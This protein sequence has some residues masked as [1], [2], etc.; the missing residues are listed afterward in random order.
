MQSEF[1][2]TAIQASKNAEK[3]IMQYYSED[4]KVEIKKDMTPVTIADK[5]AEKIIIKTIMSKFPDHEILGEE[6]GRTGESEYQWVI[7]P[8]DGTKNYMKKIPIFGTLIALVKNGE[9]IVGVSNLPALQ[10]MIY[11]EKGKG[12]WKVQGT[13]KRLHVSNCSRVSDS[14]LNSGNITRFDKLGFKNN[15]MNLISDC[16]RQRGFGD[17]YMY[18]TVCEG[19]FDAAIES[20]LSFWDIAPFAIIIPEAGGKI[21]DLK[22]RSIDIR[23]DTCVASNG[24]IHDEILKYFKSEQSIANIFK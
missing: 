15:V 23:A 8:I 16:S 24:R 13:K 11:A 18:H 19:K 2:S 7:D 12:A 14:W 6:T 10:E 9:V 4:I 17:S 22:G 5:K 3:I 20:Q 1:L 21:T